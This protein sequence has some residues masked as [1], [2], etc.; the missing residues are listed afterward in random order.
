MSFVPSC[1]ASALRALVSS[2]LR[3]L[4][5]LP[6]SAAPLLWTAILESERALF[7]PSIE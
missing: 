4:T 2:A 7:T 6:V 3:S 1:A 5:A